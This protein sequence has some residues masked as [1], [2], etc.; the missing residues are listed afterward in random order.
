MHMFSKLFEKPFVKIG[1]EDMKYAIDHST[2]YL[3][4]NTLPSNEQHC[5]I[6]N[7]ISYDIEESTLN[8]K[9]TQYQMMNCRIIIYGRNSCDNSIDK[10]YKQLCS[11]G[12][13]HIY[14]Y[15]GGLFE[16]L[17]LQD[18]YGKSDFP[19]TSNEMDILKYRGTSILENDNK[20][21]HVIRR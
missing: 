13:V 17:L 2:D 9:I 12:F 4:I 16:W 3:I 8:E 20:I 21:M 18:I 7:T 1:F 6:K 11:F 19:T 5:L 14:V 15:M 10:K